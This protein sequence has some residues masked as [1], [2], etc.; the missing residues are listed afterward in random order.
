MANDG[1]GTGWA[2]TDPTDSEFVSDGAQEIR[3]I[4]KGTRIR[5]EYEHE[6][7]AASSAGGEHKKGS[8]KAY[9]QDASPANRP[10][11]STALTSADAGRMLVASSTQIASVYDIVSGFLPLKAATD[12]ASLSAILPVLSAG[13]KGDIFTFNSAG[14]PVLKTV[15]TDNFVATC[16]AS[17]DEGWDWKEA[18]TVL[19]ALP[20]GYLS[21]FDLSNAADTAHDITVAAGAARDTTDAQNLIRSATITKQIDAAWAEGDA[22]GGFPTALVLGNNIAYRV[23]MI[24]KAGGTLDMGFDTDASATNLLA[25]ATD[26]SEFRQIGWLE[27]D[28][29]ANIRNGTWDGDL[30]WYDDPPE[31]LDTSALTTSATTVTLTCPPGVMAIL[32]AYAQHNSADAE[33]MISPNRQDDE[34]PS[35]SNP[36]HCNLKVGGTT[37][38]EADAG[39]LRI[40]TDSSQQCR[41]RSSQTSTIC[42]IS[43][44]GWIDT[45]GK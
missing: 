15:G 39:Q 36:P 13:V 5:T 41:A 7:F 21:G 11:G 17:T 10:D 18:S 34:A 43:T 33:I 26:Y 29:S 1:T 3:D 45:R 19:G 6:T 38:A 8:A 31:D 28:G 24:R 20:L 9:Y 12:N 2:E 27:T 35:Q 25:D 14:D 22:A 30:F 40:P 23:F 37:T 44:M 16:D 4:R 42:R 32:N